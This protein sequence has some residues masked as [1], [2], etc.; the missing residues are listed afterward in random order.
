MSNV[1]QR[2][3]PHL[4]LLICVIFVIADYYVADAPLINDGATFVTQ[5][6][7]IISA[8]S[9]ALGA[10]IIVRHSYSAYREKT[11]GWYLQLYGVALFLLF[12]VVGLGLSID[13]PFYDF[14]FKVG[15]QALDVAGDSFL[16]FMIISAGIRVFRI[17]NLESAI[18]V[19]V[20]VITVL[21]QV[22]IG[23]FIWSDFPQLG[24]W[25]D[26]YPVTGAYRGILI[27]SAFG[28]IMLGARMILGIES[29][30]YRRG[31]E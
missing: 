28:A 2:D 6:T 7:R 10:I 21:S 27:T 31:E 9:Q 30:W 19:I 18:V 5:S 15:F 13:H 8:F 11:E 23:E 29:G 22:P 20:L 17:R 24:L 4:I 16:M 1:V 26:N 3:L 14:L 25:L 12:V